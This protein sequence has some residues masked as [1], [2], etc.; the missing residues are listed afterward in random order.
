MWAT[1]ACTNDPQATTRDESAD[2]GR[3]S[4][5]DSRLPNVSGVFKARRVSS[6]DPRPKEAKLSPKKGET[7]RDRRRSCHEALK[8]SGFVAGEWCAALGEVGR[9][10]G[11][12]PKCGPPKRL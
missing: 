5:F 3:G 7:L 10:E 9:A 2:R 12:T 6:E 1:P 11:L 8:R 4:Q